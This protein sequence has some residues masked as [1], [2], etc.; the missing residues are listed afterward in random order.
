MSICIMTMYLFR[1]LAPCANKDEPPQ[2]PANIHSTAQKYFPV[3]MFFI[4]CRTPGK[5]A[6]GEEWKYWSAESKTT[7]S[8]FSRLFKKN[9]RYKNDTEKQSRSSSS[10]YT[11]GATDC[12]D[13]TA[14][15][16]GYKDRPWKGPQL[17]TVC[18][19]DNSLYSYRRG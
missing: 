9:F 10:A 2:T 16:N 1:I 13:A 15:S 14:N 8:N 19:T 7:G 4:I 12:A 17:R 18:N 3:V 6:A 11:T 5:P